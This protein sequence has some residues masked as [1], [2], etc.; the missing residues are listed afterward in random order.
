[1]EDDLSKKEL[2]L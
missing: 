2:C 1:M